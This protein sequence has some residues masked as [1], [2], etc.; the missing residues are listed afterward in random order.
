MMNHPM[1]PSHGLFRPRLWLLAATAWL[2]T[3]AIG[4]ADTLD[5]ALA[6]HAQS[7]LDEL[8]N[9]QCKT[10][11]VLRFRYQRGNKPQTFYAGAINQSLA[12]RLENALILA[13]SSEDPEG[14]IGIL[15]DAGSARGVGAWFEDPKERRKLFDLDQYTPAWRGG[16]V[17]PEGFLTGIVRVSADLGR[18]DVTVE[19]FT[20]DHLELKAIGK[21]SVRPDTSL[22][23]DLGHTFVVSAAGLSPTER[24]ARAIEDARQRDRNQETADPA[25]PEDTCGLSL[26]IYY[27]DVKQDITK[28]DNNGGE[29]RVRPPRKNEEVKI[30]LTHLSKTERR[31]GAL[32]RVNGLSTNR[33][34]EMDM[35]SSTLWL[36]GP[37]VMQP[38]EGFYMGDTG[39]NLLRFEVL[40]EEESKRRA[41]ESGAR[42]GL[43]ELD[44]FES[45][46]AETP[47]ATP[48]PLTLAGLSRAHLEA[49]PPE[50]LQ[51]L[52]RRLAAA[53][54][55]GVGKTGEGPTIRGLIVPGSV[56][57]KSKDIKTEDFPG[58]VHLGGIVIRY[59]DDAVITISN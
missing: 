33:K 46:P 59:Y 36:L 51:A 3:T 18:I 5:H 22:L 54:H 48:P 30:V 13:N 15:R 16:P 57:Q 41:E 47:E 52:Q 49:K 55:P 10:V 34:E 27:N 7:I 53:R 4:R 21:L 25:S 58:R 32:L 12:T 29:W 56:L 19:L 38:F 9:R 40:G 44:V 8:Y 43:I 23:R 39:K 24:A 35:D 14:P 50:N 37:R 31:L 28:D 6:Q 26:E 45:R 2:L 20:R 42:V 17:K 1:H 11:G